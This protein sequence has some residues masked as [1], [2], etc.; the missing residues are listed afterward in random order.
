M[1]T[2]TMV[3]LVAGLMAS[4]LGA[5]S[6]SAQPYGSAPAYQGR[7]YEGQAYDDR[8]YSD[9]AYRETDDEWGYDRG[10][11]VTNVRARLAQI[12][13]RIERG[14]ERGNLTRRE[15]WNARIQSRQIAQ[16]LDVYR[17]NGFNR[18]ELNDLDTRLD[19]LQA[20][21][22]LARQESEYGDRYRN[23]DPR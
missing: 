8:R 15:A 17:A 11:P 20:Q 14:L 5:A 18:W 1:K 12:D 19:Q 10:G 7:G 4:A 22:R 6:A 9:R 23:Y 2:L 21:I 3:S 16:R 13:R